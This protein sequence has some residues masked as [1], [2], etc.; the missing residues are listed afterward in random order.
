MLIMGFLIFCYEDEI[1]KCFEKLLRIYDFLIMKIFMIVE[2][3]GEDRVC[4]M[5]N[6]DKRECWGIF[7]FWKEVCCLD[8]NKYEKI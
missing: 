4:V 7:L 2:L 6:F 1:K 5:Y 3:L 8:F